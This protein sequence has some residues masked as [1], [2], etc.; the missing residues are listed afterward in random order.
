MDKDALLG[1]LKSKTVW[2]NGAVGVAGVL[3]MLASNSGTVAALFPGLAPYMA[4]FGA[5]NVILRFFTTK[6]LAAK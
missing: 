6:P 5:V 1:A 2:I 3:D 4:L